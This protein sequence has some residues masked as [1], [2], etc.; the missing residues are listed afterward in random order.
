VL[1][2]RGAVGFTVKS[3][4]AAAVLIGGSATAPRVLDSRRVEI[5]DPDVPDSIQP[6]HAG[7][8]TA[9]DGGDELKRLVSSVKKFGRRSV[10]ATL[11][12]YQKRGPLSGAGVV[13]G[14]LIDPR[15][16][17]NDHIRIHAMEGQLFRGVV[18]DAS[19]RTGLA[20]AVCRERDLYAAAAQALKKPEAAIRKALTEMGRE[21]EGGWRAEQKAAALSAWIVLGRRT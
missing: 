5:S 16:I 20:C 13:V 11:R 4:W 17:G 10:T 18:I 15:T 21:V 12:E 14:S 19:E 9:R 8:G 1:R 3:G 7:F 6:Y 2:E